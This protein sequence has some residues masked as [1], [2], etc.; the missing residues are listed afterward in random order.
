MGRRSNQHL[1][2]KRIIII[3]ENDIQKRVYDLKNKGK[4]LSPVLRIDQLSSESSPFLTVP[5]EEGHKNVD[6]EDIQKKK[7]IKGIIDLSCKPL[8]KTMSR[9]STPI[10]VLFN[11]PVTEKEFMNTYIGINDIFDSL[12]G[13]FECLFPEREKSHR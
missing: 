2:V 8:Y 5:N 6:R 13:D 3:D 12:V 9:E 1:A 10:P 4:L 7:K 11:D